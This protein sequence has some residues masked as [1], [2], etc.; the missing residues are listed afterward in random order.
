MV[1]HFFN[2][3]LVSGV[4]IDRLVIEPAQVIS[5]QVSSLTAV[6][7]H[8]HYSFVISMLR[9]R[10]NRFCLALVASI[11]QDVELSALGGFNSLHLI[12]DRYASFCSIEVDLLFTHN[13]F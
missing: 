8:Q 3:A 2:L 13:G 7:S 10:S 9:E 12:E 11:A 1:M 5:H 6:T 4:Q